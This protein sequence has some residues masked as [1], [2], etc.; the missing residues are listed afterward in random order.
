[1]LVV[2]TLLIILT[3]ACIAYCMLLN[4]RIIQ[5]QKYGVEMQKLFHDFDKTVVKSESLFAE[6][7]EIFPKSELAIA[8]VESKANRKIEELESMINKADTLA[9]ELTTIIISGNRLKGKLEITEKKKQNENFSFFDDLHE[10]MDSTTLGVAGSN[11][12]QT[13]NIERRESENLDISKL[14][15]RIEIQD[16]EEQA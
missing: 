13:A 8:T 14:A 16:K 1:M 10:N 2:D 15:S 6:T 4:R 9:E 5:I 3:L 7:K 12:Q 11:V